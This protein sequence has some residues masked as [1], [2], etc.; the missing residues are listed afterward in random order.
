MKRH[1]SETPLG[2]LI[3]CCA[4]VDWE[5]QGQKPKR[6]VHQKEVA[7]ERGDLEKKW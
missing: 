3:I 2:K 7:L 6:S 1:E 5:S 4:W